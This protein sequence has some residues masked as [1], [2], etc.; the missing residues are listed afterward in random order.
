MMSRVTSTHSHRAHLVVRPAPGAVLRAAVGAVEITAA[1]SAAHWVAA[2]MLPSTAW[3]VASAL[4]VFG[5][6]VLLQRGRVSLPA[7]FA[8]AAAGQVFQHLA[9]AEGM[10]ADHLHQAGSGLPMVVAHAA[11]AL[12]TVLVWTLRRRAWDVLVRVGSLRIA[13]FG[14]LTRV[15]NAPITPTDAWL[16]WMAAR[17]RGPP[18][19][20]CA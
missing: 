9:L 17:R 4:P 3:I 18:V 7:A 2:G 14:R 12:A 19:G 11:G 6:G 5:I 1:A 15:S 13:A 8:G 16:E 10:S 20:A